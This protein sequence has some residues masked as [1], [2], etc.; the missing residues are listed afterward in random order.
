MYPVG[1]TAPYFYFINGSTDFQ[2]V[3]EIIVT[4]PGIY[5]I[6]V[7]DANNCSANTSI[8]VDAIPEPSFSIST[9]DITCSTNSNS[10]SITI[11]VSTNNGFTLDYSIDGGLTFSNSN[12]FS[13]LT[14]GDYDVVIQYSTGSTICETI[15]Q[16]VT[17][18]ASDAIF[19]NSRSYFK[20]YM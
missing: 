20:L 9:T 2:T 17:I 5:D 4:A 10:G 16:L 1:G 13:G 18:I 15:P 14:E 6:T 7:V 12:T 3:P 11:N 8:T 19:W